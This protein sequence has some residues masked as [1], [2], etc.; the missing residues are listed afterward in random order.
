VN[1]PD[2]VTAV[3]QFAR[4]ADPV[5]AAGE[6]ARATATPGANGGITAVI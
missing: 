6:D 2:A 1:E 5:D 4:N 3:S